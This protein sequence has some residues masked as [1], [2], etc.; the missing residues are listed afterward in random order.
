M[1]RWQSPATRT[2]TVLA[3][4]GR[5]DATRTGAPWWTTSAAAAER[6]QQRSRVRRAHHCGNRRALAPAGRHHRQP[7]RAGAAWRRPPHAACAFHEVLRLPIACPAAR[8]RASHTALDLPLAARRRV[9]VVGR[10]CCRRLPHAAGRHRCVPV[11]HLGCDAGQ[12]ARL[13]RHRSRASEP[14]PRH[15][16]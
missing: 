15:D 1:R 2:F 4:R 5:D 13:R 14:R 16:R 7:A 3:V 8:W 6:Q 9:Q 10:S 11:A 12:H